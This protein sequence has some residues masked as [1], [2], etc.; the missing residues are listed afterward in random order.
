MTARLQGHRRRGLAFAVLIK[1]I[2]EKP[3]GSKF[4]KHEPLQR[5]SFQA[6]SSHVPTIA[7]NTTIKQT[8]KHI[9]TRAGRNGCKAPRGP[10]R[11]HVH[12]HN[13]QR[14]F[15]SLGTKLLTMLRVAA[16]DLSTKRCDRADVIQRRCVRWGN[17]GG[18]NCA[19]CCVFLY[20][21]VLS[22]ARK[23]SS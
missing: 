1:R 17:F 15:R 7:S 19:K 10:G 12:I 6:V 3:L 2:F 13:H 20:S 5:R 18:R 23:V 16:Q 8:M 4:Q 14:N 9:P 21:F 11:T 22:P